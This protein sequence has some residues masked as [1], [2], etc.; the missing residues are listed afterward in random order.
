[1]RTLQD[2]YTV[3]HKLLNYIQIEGDVVDEY[4]VDYSPS[5][6]GSVEGAEGT[7]SVQFKKLLKDAR[8][9]LNRLEKQK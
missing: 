2:E 5:R 3:I 9:A 6:G 8:N 1:M 4:W 7:Q